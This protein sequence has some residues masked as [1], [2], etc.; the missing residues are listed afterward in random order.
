MMR[1]HKLMLAGIM[2]LAAFVVAAT[3]AGAAVGY[4]NLCP[5]LNTALCVPAGGEYAGLAVDNSTE[6]SAGDVW[7]LKDGNTLLKFDASGNQLAEFGE[8]VVNSAYNVAVDPTSGDVYV[9]EGESEHRVSKFNS[10]GILQF[11]ITGEGASG[12]FRP[13]ALTVDSSG[14]LYVVS[15]GENEA[16]DEFSSSGNFI[17]QLAVDHGSGGS[18]GQ[19]AVDPQNNLY[20]SFPDEG[21]THRGQVREYT[22]AGAP[23]N[24][25]NGS[26][27]LFEEERGLSGL[28]ILPIAIDPTDGHII[29]GVTDPVE[30]YA[31]AEYSAPCTAS[32]TKIG[33]NEFGPVG[34]GGIG[35]NAST[36]AVYAD[37]FQG[38]VSENVVRVYG[39]VTLPD[40]TTGGSPA[41]ITRGSAAVDGTV[42][43]DG[44]EVT[45]CEFEYGTSSGYGHSTPCVQAL[46]LG[47][48]SAVAVS[49]DLEYVLPPASL[50]HYRLKAGNAS[51]VNFGEDHTFYTEALPPPVVGGVPASSVG[52]FAAVLNGS[53]RTG[54]ALV[55]Y[56]F[57]YGTTT[58]YGSVAPIPDGV[59]P[60]TNETVPVSQPVGGLQADT[61]YHYR[62]VASSPGAT[63][64][65]GPDETFTT[66]PI[67][68]PTVATGGASGVGVGVATLSGT[69]DPHGWDTTYLFQYGPSTSYGSSWPSVQVDMG[70][71]EGAQPVVVEV[72]NLLPSTTYHYRLVATNGGGTTYG[73]DMT[74]TTGAYPAQ[75]IQEP[76]ALRTL[77][78]PTGKVAKPAGKKTVKKKGKKRRRGKRR[79][80]H[81]K[82][83]KK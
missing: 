38:S 33:A 79:A 7:V 53:L 45:T 16:I 63:E 56:R 20:V 25:P 36:H 14:N 68:A 65:E 37:L 39:Q 15:R 47:G 13:N 70:A 1:I 19:I 80:R 11:R 66:L 34:P 78:V 32:H 64:V 61:T 48:N 73:P 24:C 22:S 43:P 27:I 26:N 57:E 2:V 44:T 60:I 41:D 6:A 72:P 46:P 3:P 29:V 59:T 12:S 55:N 67:T 23:A 30:R 52:Q 71:L 31:V 50:V 17:R 49:A 69:I 62:L 83:G 4:R 81:K 51:G 8:G 76:L 18:Y 40:V 42:N 10:S 75:T 21:E 9:S 28:Y 58:D 5:A 77:L 54:E 82:A 74:F 35:V